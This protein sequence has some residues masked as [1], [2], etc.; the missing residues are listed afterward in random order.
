MTSKNESEA[1]IKL[2]SDLIAS[3]EAY[4]E[5]L[6]KTPSEVIE[7]WAYLGKAAAEQ[8]T[9]YEQLMLMSGAG[10]INVG[11]RQGKS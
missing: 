8:L 9:E 10:E 2:D 7:Y 3:A 4:L 6:P 1:V 11:H 5:K